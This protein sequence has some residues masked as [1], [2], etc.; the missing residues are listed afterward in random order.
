MRR[1]PSRASPPPTPFSQ[2]RRS[3][4]SMTRA[5]GIATAHATARRRPRR[6]RRRRPGQ[7]PRRARAPI[8][9]GTARVAAGVS[10]TQPSACS[11]ARRTRRPRARRLVRLDLRDLASAVAGSGDWLSLLEL[12][13]LPT[14][15]RC[16]IGTL[17]SWRSSRARGSSRACADGLTRSATRPGALSRTPPSSRA[18]RRG[19]VR[20]PQTTAVRFR[21]AS[22]RRS[23]VRDAEQ[24]LERAVRHQR[25]VA[26]RIVRGERG[27]GA[28]VRGVGGAGVRGVASAARTARAAR[29]RPASSGRPPSARPAA[30][31]RQGRGVRR[32][33]A[34]RRN[35]GG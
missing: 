24:M 23:Q 12:E 3:V 21:D 6:G 22:R 4:P 33:R 11:G 8:A 7:L 34:L 15:R 27:Q 26:P 10:T 16:S 19:A 20:W 13:T 29:R 2:T 32:C 18:G 28:G 25:R 1:L 31:R 9:V 30:R 5:G 17:R 14:S 35:Y